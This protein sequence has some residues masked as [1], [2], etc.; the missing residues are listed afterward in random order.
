M[1]NLGL[2]EQKLNQMIL[3]EEMEN[4]TLLVDNLFKSHL[5]DNQYL[6][7]C[8]SAYERLGNT[9]QV[10]NC[11]NLLIKND[12]KNDRFYH[13]RAMIFY[14]QGKYGLFEKSILNAIDLNRTA[15]SYYQTLVRFYKMR[16]QYYDAVTVMK[17]AYRAIPTEECKK[18]LEV[19]ISL[20]QNDTIDNSAFIPV[21]PAQ[22]STKFEMSDQMIMDMVNLFSGREN[23]YARQWKDDDGKS[24]YVPVREPLTFYE[25]KNHLLGK[26]TLGVYQ[27]DIANQVRFL[28]IDLDV[29]KYAQKQYLENTRFKDFINKGFKEICN[30][31]RS[32]LKHFD[33]PVYFENSGFKGYHAWIF[34]N[35]KINAKLG[36]LFLNKL[37]TFIEVGKYPIQIELFP[38][39]SALNPDQLGNL[40]KIPMGIHLKTGNRCW[41][42][43][44]DNKII[45]DYSVIS[46]IK[47]C[48]VD[49]II[50]ALNEWKHILVD[51]KSDKEAPDKSN[52]KE[53]EPYQLPVIE[54]KVQLE[55]HPEYQ[56]LISKCFVLR[57]IIAKIENSFEISNQERL[58]LSFTL[59]H[60]SNGAEIVNI[61]LGKCINVPPDAFLKS[62]F[63]GNP[64]SCP[65]IRA[66]LTTIV[67]KEKCNCQFSS[68]LNSYPN[69]LLHLQD[70]NQRNI[71]VSQIDSVKLMRLVENYLNSKKEY[72]ELRKS[73]ENQERIIL[74]YLEHAGIEEIETSYGVL[75][76]QEIN[77]KKQ[78]TLKL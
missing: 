74:E 1:D 39:Q 27:L 33:I 28:A 35:E 73:I 8:K 37:K 65:K 77:Q 55:T 61:L 42:V 6:L 25:M 69:P 58:T 22:N 29:A 75:Q 66:R 9:D 67:E 31:I 36:L 49:K 13:E 10:I 54:K 76:I 63:S 5:G 18:E 41:F 19:C 7:F 62:N 64:V 32:I 21:K 53:N 20:L 15:F 51:V 47:P 34:L 60:L 43:D 30:Q 17:S 78:L 16:N 72:N 46:Q 70:L 2:I 44:D 11:L 50:N 68:L 12:I 45:E 40:I 71:P 48:A 14:D 57:Q 26:N 56:W 52:E 23:V 3:N 59:G 4:A 38:K 24:G